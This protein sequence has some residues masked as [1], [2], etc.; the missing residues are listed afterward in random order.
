[1][2]DDNPVGD[3]RLATVVVNVTDMRRAADFWT[4]LLG[5]ERREDEWDDEFMM[6]VDPRGRHPSVSLQAADA[7][8][9]DPTPVHLDLYTGEQQSQLQRAVELGATRV[10]DW[11]YPPDADFVVL[12]DPDGNE[13]C[14]I[15]HADGD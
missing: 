14:I 11:P 4:A 12:R 15:D 5:Y 7:I 1:M 3:L 6:L 13:F 8:P 9:K 2:T 10:E